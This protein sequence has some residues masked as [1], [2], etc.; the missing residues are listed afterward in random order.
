MV[1]LGH[2]HTVLQVLDA[3]ELEAAVQRAKKRHTKA[4]QQMPATPVA[5]GLGGAGTSAAALADPG[6]KARALLIAKEAAEVA[7]RRVSGGGE[8][9]GPLASIPLAAAAPPMQPPPRAASAAAER[10]AVGVSVLAAAA[11]GVGGA[12]AAGGPAGPEER[13]SQATRQEP[14]NKLRGANGEVAYRQD[15]DL[16]GRLVLFNVSVGVPDAVVA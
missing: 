6:I 8:A 15:E 14:D 9:A 7:A 4:R 12:A 2:L 10:P 1:D 16:Y 11:G 5:P 13:P 3:A